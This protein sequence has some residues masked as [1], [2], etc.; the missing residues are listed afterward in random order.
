MKSTR[1]PTSIVISSGII[2]F[3]VIV[4]VG[5]PEGAGADDGV[6]TGVVGDVG[7][8]IVDSPAQAVVNIAIKKKARVGI[9]F[10]TGAR[11]APLS[12]CA[13][14]LIF[15]TCPEL[16]GVGSRSDRRRPRGAR[17]KSTRAVRRTPVRSAPRKTSADQ[18][19]DDIVCAAEATL[20][21]R[22]ADHDHIARAPCSVG[23]REDA[24]EHRRR[25]RHLEEIWRR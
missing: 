3:G 19:P 1:W 12:Y 17:A 8:I 2:P 6:L 5:G 14:S 23:G 7:G 16:S 25:S 24:T 18:R 10:D 13:R 9:G 15:A 20:P 21:Q 4:I 11:P 22:M